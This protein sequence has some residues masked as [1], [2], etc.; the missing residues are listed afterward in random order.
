M[1]K[2]VRDEVLSVTKLIRDLILN[3][4]QKQVPCIVFFIMHDINLKHKLITK[5]VTAMEA[6]QLHLLCKYKT[7]EHMV[8]GQRGCEVII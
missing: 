1:H 8:E 2:L 5:S 4:T 7:K 6:L 3:S